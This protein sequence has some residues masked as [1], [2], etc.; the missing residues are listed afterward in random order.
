MVVLHSY[1]VTMEESSDHPTSEDSN[2]GETGAPRVHSQIQLLGLDNASAALYSTP[3]NR[4]SFRKKDGGTDGRTRRAAIVSASMTGKRG[5]RST[6][7][8][9]VLGN[10]RIKKERER[11]LLEKQ[12]ELQ[13]INML[14]LLI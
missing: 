6:T 13:T 7:E 5:Q 1:T 9:V 10:E 4:S 14:I 11:E 8:K 3:K 2:D 12:E